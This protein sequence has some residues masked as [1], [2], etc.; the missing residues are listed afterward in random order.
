MRHFAVCDVSLY[1]L[2]SSFFTR[3]CWPVERHTYGLFCVAAGHEFYPKFNFNPNY[4]CTHDTC[5]VVESK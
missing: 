1:D 2:E 4:V 5:K 3:Q